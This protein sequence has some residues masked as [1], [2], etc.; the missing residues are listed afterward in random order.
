M[1]VHGRAVAQRMDA[2]SIKRDIESN[3]QSGNDPQMISMNLMLYYASFI[4]YHCLTS[5]DNRLFER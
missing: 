3:F 1:L 4:A 5:F 2:M